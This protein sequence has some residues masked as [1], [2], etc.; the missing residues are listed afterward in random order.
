MALI[1]SLLKLA[2]KVALGLV[3]APSWVDEAAKVLQ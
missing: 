3:R 2:A 1:A